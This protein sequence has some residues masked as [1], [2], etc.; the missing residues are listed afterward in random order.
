M[1]V[2]IPVEEKFPL[3]SPL[4]LKE[5]LPD[6]SFDNIVSPEEKMDQLVNEINEKIET[7]KSENIHTDT[8]T[9]TETISTLPVE[10]IIETTPIVPDV[11][12]T[13]E[14]PITQ[15]VS[16]TPETKVS[17]VIPDISDTKVITEHVLEQTES[18]IPL[19]SVAERVVSN[20]QDLNNLTEVTTGLT[21]IPERQFE[22]KTQVEEHFDNI[23][24]LAKGYEDDLH[25]QE[26]EI[27]SNTE[28]LIPIE[29][30][31]FDLQ[32]IPTKEE[33]LTLPSSHEYIFE[34]GKP[35]NFGQI[36][37]VETLNNK[38]IVHPE[39]TI[40]LFTEKTNL[41][42]SSTNEFWQV[43]DNIEILVDYRNCKGILVD[44]DFLLQVF[45]TDLKDLLKNSEYKQKFLNKCELFFNDLISMAGNNQIMLVSLSK[46]TL[47]GFGLLESAEDFINIDLE[48]LSTLRNKYGFRNI[49]YCFNDVH[50]G[51]ELAEYKK[52]I[53][54]LGMRRSVSFKIFACLK[55]SY[56]LF[57]I[58][59]IVENNNLDGIIIDLDS[60]ITNFVGAN[61]HMLDDTIINLLNYVLNISN[62]NNCIVFLQNNLTI[63]EPH[64]IKQLLENGLMYFVMP[65]E[66]LLEAK[67]NIVD[68]EVARLIKKKK[69]GRKK[70]K[71]D[72]GF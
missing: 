62:S 2:N 12:I 32:T 57:S 68:Q 30:K 33:S 56:P 4:F 51:K 63:L 54:T 43:L 10:P 39:Y 53:T 58:K 27:A 7:E 6:A 41:P 5:E 31:D 36:P 38:K 14:V 26:A 17:S 8:D 42:I 49:W 67:L 66:K 55:E 29:K 71:I 20:T 35:V 23:A 48:L 11:Q 69:R 34:E 37:Q 52:N 16:I 18:P 46:K 64:Y 21:A 40:R 50:D 45:S 15:E 72:F 60:L 59:N 13:P 9:D 19:E 24:N 44:V 22:V 61:V 47:S 25:I 1:D 70:K 3:N 65:T 28:D